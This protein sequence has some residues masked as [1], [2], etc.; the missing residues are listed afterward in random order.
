MP[1]HTAKETQ[2]NA[3]TEKNAANAASFTADKTASPQPAV[4]GLAAAPEPLAYE[5]GNG[6]RVILCQAPQPGL[7]SAQLWVKTGSIHEG[8]LLGSGLSHYLEHMLFKGT[9]KRGPLDISAE[10]N[11]LG[12]N[13]NAYTT[14][15]R[16]VY[17]IDG[18][19]EGT[20]AALDILLDMGFAAALDAEQTAR[21]RDVILREIDMGLD[22]PDRRLMQAF[23]QTAFREHPYR[24]PVIG[25][26]ELFEEVS[27][28]DLRN[29]YEHRYCTDNAVLVIVTD[30]DFSQV[31]E[32]VASRAEGIRRHRK[33]P[34]T[35]LP[36]PP[37]L[38][39]RSLRLEADSPLV[40]GITGY[41][42][43]GL[44]A[45]DAPALD[46][47]A[48]LLGGGS[49]SLLWQ[50]LREQRE[51]VHHISAGCW[52]PGAQ[53]LLWVS[54]T[55]DKGRREA[56]EAAIKEE[57][58][59]IQQEAFSQKA[60][61]KIIRQSVVAELNS[62]RTASGVAARLGAAEVVLGDL[63][64]P[65]RH[66]ELLRGVT[67]EQVRQAAQNY[68][69]AHGQT[70]VSLEP[71]GSLASGRAKA[72]G[73]GQLAPFE[74]I[75]FDNG[76]RLLLQDGDSVGK[77]HLRFAALGGGLWEGGDRRGAT[78]IL[79]SL[80]TRDTAKRSAAEVAET[81]EQIGGSF[82]E[83]VGNNTFGIGLEVLSEDTPL[84]VDLLEQALLQRN[85]TQKSFEVERQGQIASLLEDDDEV[86]EWA[87]RHL[88]EQ[89]FGSHPY[90][91]DYLGREADLRALSLVE[92][93]ALAEQLLVGENAVL[94]VSGNFDKA[95]IID[96]LAPILSTL[97][98]RAL[99]A[100]ELPAAADQLAPASL[101]RLQRE[102]EQAVVLV[103]YPDVGV[104]AT[105]PFIVADLLD[106]IFSGMS[107]RL[108]R[109]VREEQGLAY[110]VGSSRISGLERGLFSFYAGTH[111]QSAE[112]VLELIDAEVNRALQCGLTADELAAAKLRLCV[113]QRQS[114][115]LCGTRAMQSALSTLYGKG[116]NAW[117]QF[118][119]QLEAISLED[120]HA[121][122][123]V[124]FSPELRQALIVSPSL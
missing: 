49:S 83:F 108:F 89:C 28:A 120:L 62:R 9:A 12:G 2:A 17:Y 102:R 30:H 55:C 95:A 121:F 20:E 42:I 43:P 122:C 98:Q 117:T 7:F 77:V 21:E 58:A 116:A 24:H 50:K 25:W 78:G 73:S 60:V 53:G 76:A 107:S 22:D 59:T 82:S 3:P 81:I 119:A 29:Y 124:H 34:V 13:I 85:S 1:E 86:L 10:V 37:Q 109:H 19:S 113:R 27:V 46:V 96:A 84:A 69:H 48:R 64:Y 94:A 123:A 52:N 65:A 106:E 16:T 32:W 91:V 79:A 33:H 8:E 38:S 115:Q 5:L 61:D 90:A 75:R 104:R 93:N 101:V 14:F 111:P 70:S 103:G 18:P 88:R 66:L 6:L 41:R 114:R 35:I 45:A 31:Q 11:A 100:P 97:P 4:N 63:D 99:P 67:P 26:R 105:K 44:S 40:R 72:Q 92:T 56:V 68:F 118:D 57:L 39:Q 71:K 23:T 47:L 80:L 87:R 110:Y 15:D 36:E 51:L 54:Y 74:E 112:R